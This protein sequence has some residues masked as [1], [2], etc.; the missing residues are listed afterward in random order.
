METTWAGSSFDSVKP[1][2]VG[3]F[4]PTVELGAKFKQNQPF[5]ETREGAF[6]D[7]IDARVHHSERVG[8]HAIWKK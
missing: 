1:S 4:D 8:N 3:F 2:S 5:L 7:A 6:E